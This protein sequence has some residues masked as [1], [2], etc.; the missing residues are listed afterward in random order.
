MQLRSDA[1]RHM[2][3]DNLGDLRKC[4][5]LFTEAIECELSDTDGDGA[6]PPWLPHNDVA[7]SR[8]I[9]FRD[10]RMLRASTRGA[11]NPIL[12]QASWKPS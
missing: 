2:D 3:S 7:K 5:Q 9:R 10:L 11:A 1:V 6:S 4:D 8:I 12:S